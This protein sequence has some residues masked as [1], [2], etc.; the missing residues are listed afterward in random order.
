MDARAVGQF[1]S[2]QWDREIISR[3]IEYIRIPCK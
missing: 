3:L 1:V 2:N